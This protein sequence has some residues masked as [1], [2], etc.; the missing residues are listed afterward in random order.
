M[1][2]LLLVIL[3]LLPQACLAG[4]YE[5]MAAGVLALYARQPG[6]PKP[7]PGPGP[8]SD[9]C[10]NCGGTGKLGDGTITFPCGECDGTGKKKKAGSGS[11]EPRVIII[12]RDAAPPET[13]PAPPAKQAAAA[14]PPGTCQIINGRKVCTPAATPAATPKTQTRSQT[15]PP[16]Y[17]TWRFRR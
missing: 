8:V 9:E 1:Y 11:T 4:T 15:S 12:Y 16:T 6:P 13:P 7:A 2:R 10:E 17:R 3:M 14:P 5:N